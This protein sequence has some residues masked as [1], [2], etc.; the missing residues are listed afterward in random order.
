MK[1]LLCIFVSALLAAGVF[2]VT[3]SASGISSVTKTIKIYNSGDIL[4][5]EPITQLTIKE[6]QLLYGGNEQNGSESVTDLLFNSIYDNLKNM[7]TEIDISS[8]ELLWTQENINIVSA[9]ALVVSTSI[10]PI[11]LAVMAAP[12]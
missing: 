1:K 7:N 12:T 5:A 3:A 8:L 4:P 10:P 6:Q 2:G 9:A 11:P